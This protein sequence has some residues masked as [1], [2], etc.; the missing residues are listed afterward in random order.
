MDN[1]TEHSDISHTLQLS[2][3]SDVRVPHGDREQSG[4]V[5][6]KGKYP[7]RDKI[8][9]EPVNNKSRMPLGMRT[10]IHC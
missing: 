8:S 1:G 6:S 3:K 10:K 7:V 9:V 5:T 2:R 4:V